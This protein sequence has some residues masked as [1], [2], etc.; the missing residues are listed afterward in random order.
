MA[1]FELDDVCCFLGNRNNGKMV[2]K[3]VNLSIEDEAVVAV[4]GPS[5]AG[6]S[7]LLN[8]LSGLEKIQSGTILFNG[9]DIGALSENKRA[10]LRLKQFG[11]VFQAFNLI[12]SLSVKDNIVLPA[13]M[14]R[15]KIEPEYYRSVLEML[16]ISDLTGKLPSQISG[17]EMQRVAIARAIINHPKVVFA[18][19]PTGNLDSENGTRVFELLLRCAKE[20]K[21]TLIFATHDISK[22]QLA[23]VHVEVFDGVVKADEN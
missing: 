22:A 10:D 9:I 7:T 12:P 3:N 18:D 13:A 17:G 23:N 8:V 11:F 16:G 4:T 14:C 1:L 20:F 19:E 5:G 15:A 21:Q 2:L 6:K